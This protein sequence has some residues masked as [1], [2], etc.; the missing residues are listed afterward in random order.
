ME[1]SWNEVGRQLKDVI[2]PLVQEVW[3]AESVMKTILVVDDEPV[4]LELLQMLLEGAGYSVVTVASGN[5]AWNRILGNKDMRIDVVISDVRMPD[6]NGFEL[7]QKVRAMG[8]TAPRFLFMTGYSDI[9][10]EQMLQMGAVAVVSKPFAF[11]R[12][13]ELI[14]NDSAPP[15]LRET[16]IRN[17]SFFEA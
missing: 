11:Q 1:R 16:A 14:E 15:C 5:A 6:G 4:I 9:T 17:N 2:V 3:D 8:A 13:L 12:L 10:F 7:L